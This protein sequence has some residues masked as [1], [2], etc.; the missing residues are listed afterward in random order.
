MVIIN[1]SINNVK[2]SVNNASFF[3]KNTKKTTKKTSVTKPHDELCTHLAHTG[4]ILLNKKYYKDVSRE[5][6]E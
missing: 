3:E 1:Q 4:G 2:K 5:F 6:D